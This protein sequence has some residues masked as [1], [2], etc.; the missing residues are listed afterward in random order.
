MVLGCWLA[1]GCGPATEPD[2][3]APDE[4]TRTSLIAHLW[5]RDTLPANGP[6]FVEHDVADPWIPGLS[7]VSAVDRLWFHVTMG[8]RR[9]SNFIAHHYHPS[10]DR[11]RLVIYHDGHCHPACPSARPTIQFFLDRGFSVLLY[12]MPMYGAN[13]GASWAR[14]TARHNVLATLEAEGLP[15]MR[16]FFDQLARGMNYVEQLGYS[17]IS[18]IGYSGGGWESTLYPA[19]DP[20]VVYSFAVAGT[21]PRHLESYDEY[22]QSSERPLY[23]IADYEQLYYLAA[24][25]EGRRHLQLLNLHDPCCWAAAG[26]EDQIADYAALIADEMADRGVPGQFGVHIVTE[27]DGH[28]ISPAALRYVAGVLSALPLVDSEGPGKQPGSIA[29]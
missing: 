2:F 16:L 6:T 28:Q 14:Q 5:Q 18:M 13:M 15:S 29:R 23:A 3:V 1:M 27:H 22:E 25:G 9:L 10:N 8:D 26:R 21:M 20:R 4:A 24:L 7:N 17:D 11:G 12:S 19:L